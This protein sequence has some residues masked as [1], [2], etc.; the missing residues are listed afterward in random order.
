MQDKRHQRNA[1]YER[2][3]RA[4][5]A[6]ALRESAAAMRVEVGSNVSYFHA[7]VKNA[8]T[9]DKIGNSPIFFF[10]PSQDEIMVR[11]VTFIG[12]KRR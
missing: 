9:I 8:S 2:E 4:Q 12:S 3:R 1:Q 5:K 6:D 10:K 7:K 11:A